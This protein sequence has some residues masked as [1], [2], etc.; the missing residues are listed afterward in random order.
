[1]PKFIHPHPFLIQP[2][3]DLTARRPELFHRSRQLSQKYAEGQVVTDAELQAIGGALWEALGVQA[4]FDAAHNAAGNAILPVLIESEAAEIQSLPWEILHHPA[5]GFL[6]RHPA[7]TLARRLGPPAGSPPPLQKGPLRVLLFTSLP[8]NAHPEQARLDVEEEQAQ[9]QSALLPWIAKGLVTLEMPDDGR[10]ETLKDWLKDFDPHVVF[11]SGHGRFYGEAHREEKFGVFLFEDE[12]GNGLEVREEA[13]AEAFAGTNVQAVILSAC[14][15]GKSASD[16]LNNG[17]TRR[18]SAR[19]IPHVIGMR[20]SVLDQAGIRFA[21][22]LCD[23]LARA[24]RLDAALQ[25]AR[26]AIQTPF[27]GSGTTRRE[28]GAAA[29]DELSYG[30]WSLPLLFSPRPE[31]PLI[32]WDFA[33]QS[34]EIE[35]RLRLLSNVSLPPRFIGRRRELRRYQ[36]ALRE[37]TTRRLLITGPG[38]QGKTALAGKLA[39]DLQKAGWKVFAWSVRP[40][41]RWKDFEFEMEWA[42]DEPNAKKFDRYRTR[43]ENDAARARFLLDL[44]SEQ[45]GGRLVLFLDNLESVQ[46]GD[47][48]AVTD[49]AVA[50]WLEALTPSP[51][52]TGREGI[53]L[54]VTSRWAPPNWAGE[55]LELGRVTYGDFLQIARLRLPAA[56]WQNRER[57]RRAYQ[58]LGGNPRG[59]EFLAAAV[60]GMDSAEEHAFLAALEKTKEEVQANMALDAIYARLP[61]AAQ[62]LLRRLPAYREPVPAE[63]ILKLAMD[64]PVGA[65]RR[66]ALTSSALL[67]RLLAVS[68]LEVSYQHEWDA[69]EYALPPLVSDWLEAR[70]LAD[71]SPQWK[72]LAADYHLY[73]L[74]NER[75]TLT[76]AITAHHALRRA[77]RNEEADRLTLDFIVAPLTLAGFYTALLTD[78][79]PRICGS[80]DLALRGR[81]LNEMGQRYLNIGDP[82]KALVYL[83]QALDVTRQTDHKQGEGALLNNISQI[84]DAQ[85]DYETALAY[86]K[87]SLAICQQ[88]GDKEGEGTTL[89]NISQIFKAQGDY[90]TALAYLKQSLQIRQQIGDKA[91]EGATL[92]NMAAIAHAQGDYATALAYL[93]QSLQIRQQIGDKAGEG[94]TLNNMATIAHAQGDYETALEYLKQSLAI[95]R[96]IGDKAGEGTTLNNISQ[97]FKAQGDYATAL[98]YLKQSLTI[99]QQI[100]DKAGEG[101]TLNNIAGIFRAQG[102]YE[103]AL[104]YLKQSLAI[105]Q[106]IG[107]KA[108]EGT[109]LNNISQIYDAQG[110]YATALAYLKQSLT[111][112]QQIGD[113]A[114][115][116]ATLF[117]MGHIYMQNEQVQEAV[118]AWVTV[119]VIAKQ[120]NLAQALK[121]LADL[122]PQLGLPE[123]LEG[124]EM[125]AKRMKDEG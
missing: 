48:L 124:W 104:A 23:E 105:C 52:P 111:I 120:M 2:P 109:T 90:E 108:G 6:G 35:K 18:L 54:L 36:N 113:K 59:L 74:E 114:G 119:Y 41:N 94:R 49:P 37:G 87:Q 115:L 12:A 73:L 27:Q 123:G 57:M 4:E 9:V 38:G 29:A 31:T 8:E 78:W 121:A 107:D 13:L 26:L 91:G 71:D 3:A 77:D 106:Q 30:Q 100:G 96:Q 68:L 44:L 56:F 16:L 65:E 84:Y 7:F 79:L 66:S 117:N 85:G 14:E 21:R 51:S 33:P 81:A 97:I 22:A 40:E 5:L 118:G 80:E 122:A 86:L 39:L 15:S 63:G 32:D 34:V 93:K 28:A 67:E 95:Q 76:Q 47:S 20:E 45:F 25:A 110:D 99:R 98:A 50:A 75:R 82:E 69:V 58:A 103:T 89:N 17:L 64:L 102:D 43:F 1:M 88:I 72:R 61:A 92:N 60:Q 46:D 112:R 19:G 24:E 116:C 55:H 10:F 11:L 42:L 83:K 62:T 70:R 53:T 101:T 125:L